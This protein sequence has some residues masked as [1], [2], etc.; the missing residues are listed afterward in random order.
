MLLHQLIRNKIPAIRKGIPLVNIAKN[1]LRP[2]EIYENI[3]KA[4]APSVVMNPP[5][6]SRNQAIKTPIT[7]IAT[8]HPKIVPSNLASGVGSTPFLYSTMVDKVNARTQNAPNMTPKI[9]A[10]QCITFVVLS[11]V[12]LLFTLDTLPFYL[13]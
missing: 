4:I 12:F 5:I 9:R 10:V 3:H 6:P 8:K 7:T 2:A 1:L 13:I 11:L